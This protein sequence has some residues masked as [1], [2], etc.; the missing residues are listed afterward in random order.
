MWELFCLTSKT[1]IL[2]MREFETRDDPAF[3]VVLVSVGD[4]KELQRA[5]PNYFMDTQAFI[6]RLERLL[7]A[8]QY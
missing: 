4:V 7:E 2:A 1:P 6:N 8:R 5:Y 3:S